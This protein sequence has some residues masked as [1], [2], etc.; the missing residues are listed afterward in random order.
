LHGHL[1]LKRIFVGMGVALAVLACFLAYREIFAPADIH[2]PAFNA[3]PLAKSSQQGLPLTPEARDDLEGQIEGHAVPWLWIAFVSMA[4]AT[5]LSAAVSFYLYRW[6]R[7]LMANPHMMVPEELGRWLNR[8]GDNFL[9]LTHVFE[10]RV[11]KLGKEGAE[12]R[13]EVTNLVE[14]FMTL[15]SALDDRDAEIRRL[16]GGYD[17]AVFRKF[18][19]RF[20][21]VDRAI[22]DCINA[23]EPTPETLGQVQRVLE[24]AF[25]ECGVEAFEP[26]IGGD[27]R[28]AEG[29]ADNPKTVQLRGGHQPFEI[30]EVLEPGYRI[31]LLEGGYDV[32]RPAKVCIFAASS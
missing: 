15:Q 21:R 23:E 24:D 31:K 2:V 29:V 11:G 8:L 26:R 27:Y 30:A 17:A 19:A 32:V 25:A 22:E 28:K 3:A 5:L 1:S 20:I 13:R 7:I 18:V 6:R 16:K 12:T 14:T 10:N 4:F 9:E